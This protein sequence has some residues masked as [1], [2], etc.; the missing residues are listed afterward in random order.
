M[1]GG[2]WGG[3]VDAALKRFGG[4]FYFADDSATPH[5]NK[6]IESA[7]IGPMSPG[8]WAF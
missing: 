6:K 3:R 7:T 8:S 2:P 5:L 1:D 4:S